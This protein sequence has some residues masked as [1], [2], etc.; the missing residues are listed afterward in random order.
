VTP[1]RIAIV[2]Q[3]RFHAFDLARALSRRGHDVTVFTTYPAWAARRF[4]LGTARVRSAPVHGVLARGLERLPRAIRPSSADSRLHRAFG[5]WAARQVAGSAWDVVHCWSGVSEELLAAAGRSAR[6][7]WLMRG[8]AHIDEQDAILGDEARRTGVVLDRPAP[9]MIARERREYALAD[10]IVVL[11]SFARDSFRRRGVPADKVLCLPLGVDVRAF[12]PGQGALDARA[13]RVRSG[14]PLRCLYVGT[15]SL[16]KGLW[17]LEA[18]LALAPDLPLEVRLVGTVTP[19]ARAILARMD[20]RVTHRD[21]VPQHDLPAEY[22]AADVFLFPTLE[23]GFGLVLA[24][25]QAAGLPILCTTNCAG[26]DLIADGRNGWVLPIRAPQAFA[27]R[28]RRCHGDREALAAVAESAARTD[29]ARDWS[30]VAAAFEDLAAH[31]PDL[32]ALK[33][34]TA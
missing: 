11:S 17:D 4:D 8:S 16:R 9:W 3:G 10:R 13:A 15:L 23:D 29:T 28:L 18:A 26:P 30:S 27:D 6:A 19:E 20:A 7:T 5:A 1:L 25:A 32:P 14:A 31:V 12:R 21:A 24:Q 33:A 22:A 34:G 2:V